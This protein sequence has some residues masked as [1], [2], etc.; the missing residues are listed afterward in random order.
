MP[1]ASAS[2]SRVPRARRASSARPVPRVR[3]DRVG[4]I[5]MLGVMMAIVYLYLSAG[6]R[7]FSAWGESKRDVTQASMLERQH[8]ALQQQ[9]ALLSSPGTVQAEARRLGMIHPGEQAY[10]VSGLPG[11]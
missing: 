8:K 4:R 2:A 7:L 6:V 9:H 1:T 11:N 5:A 10:I 3:W